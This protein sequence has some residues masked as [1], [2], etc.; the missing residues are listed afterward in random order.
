MEELRFNNIS[1]IRLNRRE[2]MNSLLQIYWTLLLNYQ[3]I[4]DK[5]LIDE[6]CYSQF[7]VLFKTHYFH[8]FRYMNK[9]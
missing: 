5:L 9:D 1:N 6:N 3:Y 4:T 7:T 8:I 2:M